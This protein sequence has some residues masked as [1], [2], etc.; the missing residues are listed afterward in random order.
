MCQDT[1]KKEEIKPKI[2]KRMGIIKIKAEI[3]E[4]E[5]RQLTIMQSV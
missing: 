3:N 2:S 5:A 1:G 4:T